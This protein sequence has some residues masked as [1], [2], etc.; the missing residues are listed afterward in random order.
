MIKASTQNIRSKT[1]KRQII[2]YL[3]LRERILHNKIVF[4]SKNTNVDSLRN[5]RSEIAKLIG[6][7]KRDSIDRKIR[8]MHIHIHNQNDY[9]NSRKELKKKEIKK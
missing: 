8:D 1:E 7:I 9:E 4:P 5:R 6:F 3:L 2:Q